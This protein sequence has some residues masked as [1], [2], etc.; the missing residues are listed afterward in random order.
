[1][2]SLPRVSL[3]F[4]LVLAA[5]SSALATTAIQLSDAALTQ[6]SELIVVGR[7]ENV[8]SAWIDRILVTLAEVQVEETLKG[9]VPSGKITV[10][11]PGGMDLNRDVPIAMSY[12]GAPQLAPGERVFLFLVGEE[13]VAGSYSVVGFSQGKFT[14]VENGGAQKVSRDLKGLTLRSG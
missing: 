5:A 11:L 14:I 8:R 12:A 9:A 4:C 10:T 13:L 2:R 6:Q 7:V 3:V 1:M